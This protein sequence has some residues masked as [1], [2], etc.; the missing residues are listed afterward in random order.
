MAS[1]TPPSSISAT[2]R[3]ILALSA[4]PSFDV[5]TTRTA[6]GAP[7]LFLALGTWASSLPNTGALEFVLGFPGVDPNIRG[8][9]P[10]ENG[11]T[12]LIYAVWRTTGMTEQGDDNANDENDNDDDDDDDDDN[13]AGAGTGEPLTVEQQKSKADW[14][15]QL[16][17]MRSEES[18]QTGG[19]DPNEGKASGEEGGA[20]GGGGGEGCGDDDDTL[21][22]QGPPLDP[23]AGRHGRG[24]RGK[25]WHGAVD[26]NKDGTDE[27]YDTEGGVTGT[28]ES[29]SL[30]CLE[31]LLCCPT[32]D[33]NAVDEDLFTAL[34]YAVLAVSCVLQ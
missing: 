34:H 8:P 27:E 18:A 10:G 1:S 23:H 2:H 20:A 21:C 31:L 24:D 9:E 7:P 4:A 32:I 26:D 22:R 30:R 6:G 11:T 13:D 17:R 19:Q 16:A 12:A 29:N 33:V 5:N 25:R 14:E 3:E 28:P 15:K